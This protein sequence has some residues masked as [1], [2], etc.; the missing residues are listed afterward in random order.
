MYMSA[1]PEIKDVTIKRLQKI[2]GIDN[3]RVSIDWLIN[4]ALNKMERK[5]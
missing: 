1:R 4:S 3:E 2:T 5:K